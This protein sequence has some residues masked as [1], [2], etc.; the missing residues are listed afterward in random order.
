MSVADCSIATPTHES[1]TE[2][3]RSSNIGKRSTQSRRVVLSG[4]LVECRTDFFADNPH[5][6]V[7][8]VRVSRIGY[9]DT[10]VAVIPMVINSWEEMLACYDLY[11]PI[12]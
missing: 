4:T 8:G 3:Q 7:N 9:A 6:L 1:S 5:A 11:P 12:L 10:F 2:L